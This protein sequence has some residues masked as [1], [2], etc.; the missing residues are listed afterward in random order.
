MGGEWD[1]ETSPVHSF[2]KRNREAF[3]SNM[4]DVDREPEVTSCP[5]CLVEQRRGFKDGQEYLGADPYYMTQSGPNRTRKQSAYK[6]L[7]SVECTFSAYQ[8]P[9]MERFLELR[10]KGNH[11]PRRWDSMPSPA[12]ICP[13]A[14]MDVCAH[15]NKVH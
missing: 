14:M 15:W 7:H 1:E 4:R 13:P 8:Q 6:K 3:L 2:D 11:R 5:T 12:S 10:F 9:M